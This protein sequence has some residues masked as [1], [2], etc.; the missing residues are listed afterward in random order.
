MTVTGACRNAEIHPDT[1][2]EWLKS[3]PGFKPRMDRAREEGIERWE[4]EVARRAFDGVRKLKINDGQAVLDPRVHPPGQE[5]PE[6]TP[7][8]F[9]EEVEYSDA[10]AKFMLQAAS[11]EKYRD[12]TEV[13][14]TGALGVA[15]SDLDRKA[16]REVLT[17][18]AARAALIAAAERA[19]EAEEQAATGK[20]GA[21]APLAR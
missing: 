9:L 18:P 5:I 13:K 4:A 14:H 12:R 17:D 21:D 2:Y 15:V 19:A 11:P 16:A 7:L 10:L 20:G 1:V 3:D 8:V 6:G